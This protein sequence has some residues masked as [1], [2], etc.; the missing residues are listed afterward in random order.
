MSAAALRLQRL[1]ELRTVYQSRPTD[2]IIGLVGLFGAYEEEDVLIKWALE[3]CEALVSKFS[4]P[5][6]SSSAPLVRR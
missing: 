5:S 4:C 3:F 6:P 2:E 1:Q